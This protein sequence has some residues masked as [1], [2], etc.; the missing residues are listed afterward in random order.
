MEIPSNTSV[1]AYDRTRQWPL[2]AALSKNYGMS[3]TDLIALNKP[4]REPISNT[5]MLDTMKASQKSEPKR[6]IL[7]K[8]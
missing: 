6:R 1:R 2:A 5:S 8:K 3:K 7:S 4:L